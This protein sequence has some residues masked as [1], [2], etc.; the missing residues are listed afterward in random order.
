VEILEL[1]Q[2]LLANSPLY[3]GNKKIR[4]IEIYD[5]FNLVDV[6]YEDEEAVFTI[7]QMSIIQ[8]PNQE[9]YINLNKIGTRG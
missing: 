9:I 7:D 3:Y 6:I 5:L 4:I 8:Q 1:K 2:S